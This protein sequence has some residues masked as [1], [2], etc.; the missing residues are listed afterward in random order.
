MGLVIQPRSADMSGRGMLEELF[1]DRVLVE[2]GDRAQPP[3]DGRAGAPF[4]FQVAGEAFDVGAVDGEQW[5]SG[6]SGWAGTGKAGPGPVP[7]VKREPNVSRLVRS[8]Y[9]TNE[10]VP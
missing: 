4:G 8:R 9:V 2:P 10:R 1:F 6:T 5:S 7:A 3:G